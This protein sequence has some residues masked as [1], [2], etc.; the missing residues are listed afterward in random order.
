MKFFPVFLFACLCFFL[1]SCG[2]D[3]AVEYAFEGCSESGAPNLREEHREVLEYA[4]WLKYVTDHVGRI[5]YYDDRS[6]SSGGK[7][8]YAI[9]QPGE[10]YIEVATLNRSEVEICATLVHEAAHLANGCT[11]ETIPKQ[12]HGQFY[13]DY[14]ARAEGG[15]LA[16][17]EFQLSEISVPGLIQDFYPL[18]GSASVA[19]IAEDVGDG[20][21]S[22]LYVYD[23]DTGLLEQI[24]PDSGK[25]ITFARQYITYYHPVYLNQ[26]KNPWSSSGTMIAAVAEDRDRNRELTVFDRESHAQKTIVTAKEFSGAIFSPD[27]QYLAVSTADVT[28]PV[29]IF[30]PLSGKILATLPSHFTGESG[31]MVWMDSEK[32]A[33]YIEHLRQIH[34]YDIQSAQSRI[35]YSL[36]EDE[37]SISGLYPFGND[38]FCAVISTSGS[39]GFKEILRISINGGTK[40]LADRITGNSPPALSP[41][42]DFLAAFNDRPDSRTGD[43][44][45]IRNLLNGTEEI[46]LDRFTEKGAVFYLSP[47][48]LLVSTVRMNKENFRFDYRVWLLRR[49][50]F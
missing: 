13:A 23:T 30:D 11:S 3:D 50:S 42:Q 44:L 40:L 12:M 14:Y 41:M 43:Q 2:A 17:K 28:N 7:V 20:F 25:R 39:E 18:A 4:G 19:L 32:L 49:Y 5:D 37:F 33:V 26:L 36:G 6:A 8:G 38:S 46:C 21:Q 27:E 48:T 22:S 47:D 31:A 29:R 15:E 16:S 10:C 34:L 1:L 24:S 45:L 9:C 35:L